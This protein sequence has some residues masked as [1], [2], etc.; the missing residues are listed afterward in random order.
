MWD[1]FFNVGVPKSAIKPQ[2]NNICVTD[3][4]DSSPGYAESCPLDRSEPEQMAMTCKNSKL[5]SNNS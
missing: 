1:F 4:E 3:E 2:K 5:L